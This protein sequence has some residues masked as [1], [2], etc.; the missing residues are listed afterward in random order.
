[1]SAVLIAL[2][3][4]LCVTNADAY[5]KKRTHLFR[6]NL[7]HQWV[8]RYAATRYGGLCLR[9]FALFTLPVAGA[10]TL[11]SASAITVSSVVAIKQGEN[12]T[13]REKVAVLLIL[14]AVVIRSL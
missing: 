10:A 6:L 9:L 8:F 11:F 5:V 13:D 3:A 7:L 12:I 14:A 1:M 2:L 4:Q